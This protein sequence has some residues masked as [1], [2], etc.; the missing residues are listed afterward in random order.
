MPGVLRKGIDIAGGIIT[1][2]SSKVFADGVG[3]VRIGDA[4]TPHSPGG[5]HSSAVMSQGSN[6]VFADGIAVCRSGDLAS[7]G[8]TG[9]PGSNKVFV[10]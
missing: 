6:K 3:V 5:S 4:I 7:C 8:D 9:S 1:G 2:G 10:G